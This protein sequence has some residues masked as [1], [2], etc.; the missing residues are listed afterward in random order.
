MEKLTLLL[1]LLSV[2]GVLSGPPKSKL[3]TAVVAG[4]TTKPTELVCEFSFNAYPGLKDCIVKKSIALESLS[5]NA[6]GMCSISITSA[7]VDAQTGA[8][9]SSQTISFSGDAQVAVFDKPLSQK[10]RVSA[11]ISR[12]EKLV[13]AE[14]SLQN[15]VPFEWQGGSDMK[16]SIA[17][18]NVVIKAQNVTKAASY[19]AELSGSGLQAT[20]SP[21][22][23]V[24]SIE[25][26]KAVAFYDTVFVLI[27][28]PSGFKLGGAVF[29]NVVGAVTLNN[30]KDKSIIALSAEVVV[31]ELTKFLGDTLLKKQSALNIPAAEAVRKAMELIGDKP[32]TIKVSLKRGTT[33]TGFS[34]MP[35]S[36]SST[37]ENIKEVG[38]YLEALAIPEGLTISVS[39]ISAVAAA[40]MLGVQL[41]KIFNMEVTLN[42]NVFTA[43]PSFEANFVYTLTT[44]ATLFDVPA[45]NLRMQFVSFGGKVAISA[46]P[47]VQIQGTFNFRFP[48]LNSNVNA[49]DVVF[50]AAAKYA[51][52][53]SGSVSFQLAAPWRS[54]FGITGLDVT[55]LAGELIYN[56]LAVAFGGLSGVKWRA[57]MQFKAVAVDTA[58]YIDVTDITNFC[59]YFKLTAA[60]KMVDLIG[61][62]FPSAVPS[63]PALFDF[64]VAAPQEVYFAS[65]LLKKPFDVFGFKFQSGLRVSI[66]KLPFLLIGLLDLSVV[67]T[68]TELMVGATLALNADLL[69]RFVQTFA[70]FV[71]K[72]FPTLIPLIQKFVSFDLTSLFTLSAVELMPFGWKD[73]KV[74]WPG[75]KFTFPK[76]SAVSK[77]TGEEVTVPN[78]GVAIDFSALAKM[79]YDNVMTRVKEDAWVK[80]VK[81][82]VYSSKSSSLIQEEDS[83]SDGEQDGAEEHAHTEEETEEGEE[84]DGETHMN[85]HKD[86]VNAD[87]AQDAAQ[88][89]AMT[90]KQ[91]MAVLD[92]ATAGMKAR[93]LSKADI[94]DVVRHVWGDLMH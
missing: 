48:S 86:A 17:N 63:I 24:L 60:F 88:F 87:V 54:V 27:N 94:E 19:S 9:T 38:K 75:L 76:D 40:R 50:T 71:T 47:E 5:F 64:A 10:V 57:G 12:A 55:A 53:L 3:A 21:F 74:V 8:A 68:S 91:K 25:K 18:V 14:F 70:D 42:F 29:S 30:A 1:L 93:V 46:K 33:F 65:P 34:G 59:V 32:P 20:L 2:F 28:N 52:P 44:P 43:A 4:V 85:T 39:S 89:R 81:E 78:V 37:S 7:S 26:F 49:N 31:P 11:T 73:G 13:G 15:T 61:M 69:R 77:V 62:A 45:K 72:M 82:Y 35:N 22:L 56:P 90:L 16:A 67:S 36:A 51:P 66:K 23:P 41:P 84:V 79:I 58:G 92:K 6:P 83:E 80:A